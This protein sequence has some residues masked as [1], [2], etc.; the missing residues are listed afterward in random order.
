MKF[1]V[2]P[3]AFKGTIS[4][5]KAAGIISTAIIQKMAEAKITLCAIADGGDGTCQLL[6]KQMEVE[7]IGTLAVEQVGKP[8]SGSYFLDQTNKTD[9]IYVST[10]S[11]IQ[12][13]KPEEIN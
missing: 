7:E 13:L 6:G 11:G 4:A 3:N 2:A 12:C 5:D 9:Y 8:I 1:L 10:V